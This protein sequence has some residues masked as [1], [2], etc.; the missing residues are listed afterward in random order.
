MWNFKIAK[1]R[2]LGVFSECT[3]ETTCSAML[4]RI[5]HCNLANPNL[6]QPTCKNTHHPPPEQGVPPQDFFMFVGFFCIFMFVVFFVFFFRVRVCSRGFQSESTTTQRRGRGLDLV[7]DRGSKA[8]GVPAR[9]TRSV[10][11]CGFQVLFPRF[12][13]PFCA[14]GT[15]AAAAD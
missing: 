5:P 13:H 7:T 6:P 8:A 4:N 1:T 3:G 2:I 10:V 11:V 14:A 9:G 15:F 12:M